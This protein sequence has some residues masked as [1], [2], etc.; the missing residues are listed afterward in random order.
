VN[1][2]VTQYEYND[3]NDRTV[4]RQGSDEFLYVYD[5]SRR[6][7]S[8]TYPNGIVKELTYDGAS[9]VKQ[10]KYSKDSE[11]LIQLDYCFDPSGN[12]VKRTETR[13]GKAPVE[14]GYFYD[15]LNQLIRGDI[16][17]RTVS[18]YEYD[19]AGNRLKKEFTI[20]RYAIQTFGG[21]KGNLKFDT[22]DFFVG[23]PLMF[24]QA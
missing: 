18:R 2:I 15:E 9:R 21:L 7:T 17:G 24:R 14:Y 4:I 19:P 10:I 13:K 22:V 11:T 16:N 23:S 1:G 20:N 6:V 12:I 5:D 3:R 8:V